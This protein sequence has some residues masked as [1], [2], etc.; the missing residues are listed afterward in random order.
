MKDWTIR[1]RIWTSF[2]VILAL[3]TVTAT[4][5]Y[6]R[7][8]RI[9]QLTSGI[10]TDILPRLNSSNQIMVERMANYSLTQE[11]VL[12]TDL[13][14]RTNLQ[15]AILTSRAYM[16]TLA[17]QVQRVDQ[18]PAQRELLESFKNTQARYASAQDEVLAAGLDP[19]RRGEIAKKISAQ[20]Y[21][22][23]EKTG[24]AAGALVDTTSASQST[25][26]SR[27]SVGLSAASL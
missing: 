16:E 10:E 26:R 19:N 4:I 25:V 27:G 22:E 5:A 18:T 3:M 2:A 24:A 17:E 14:L 12:E 13:S 8:A 20:L 11:Y 9:E 21:P 15:A 6:T 1:R 7:L 23:F